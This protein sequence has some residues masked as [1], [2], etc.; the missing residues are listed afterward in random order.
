MWGHSLKA[1][2][3]AKRDTSVKQYV[4]TAL[5]VQLK[6]DGEWT[7]D[8][9]LLGLMVQ[10]DPALAELWDNPKDAGYDRF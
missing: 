1:G 9:V 8:N 6:R 2:S 4:L 10:T 5:T 7:G 3:I